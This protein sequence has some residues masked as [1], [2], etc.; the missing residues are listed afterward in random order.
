MALNQSTFQAYS[1]IL[2]AK[3]QGSDFNDEILRA[4][5]R[6]YQDESPALGGVRTQESMLFVSN[7]VIKRADFRRRTGEL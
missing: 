1:E 6:K 2:M 5:K 7:G 4:A 3:G